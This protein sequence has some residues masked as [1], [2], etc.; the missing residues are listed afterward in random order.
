[1]KSYFKRFCMQESMEVMAGVEKALGVLADACPGSM[2]ADLHPFAFIEN[3]STNTRA[4]IL[5]H[6]SSR[7]VSMT[8]CL[9]PFGIN[10]VVF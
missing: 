2:L 8:L 10:G 5:R 1:V 9:L 3:K 6:S 4:M 7:Q